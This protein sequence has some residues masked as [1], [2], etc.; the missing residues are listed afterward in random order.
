MSTMPRPADAGPAERSSP[1]DSVRLWTQLHTCTVRIERSVRTQL[2]A[3]FPI[4]LA[5]F[6][7]L[8]ELVDA[9]QGLKMSELSRR[10]MVSG[11]N[12]TGLTDQLVAEHLVERRALAGDRRA[13]VVLLTDAGRQVH[14]SMASEHERLI[15][16][17]LNGLTERERL[18]LAALLE[19]VEITLAENEQA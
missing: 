3:R 16:D 1:T 17:L 19:R 15:A 2:R 7:L 11:G 9:P 4:S 10:L 12:V 18:E 13:H 14:E 6:E 8:A 5:R